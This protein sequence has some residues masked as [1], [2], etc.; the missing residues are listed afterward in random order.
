MSKHDHL[1]FHEVCTF[2]NDFNQTTATHKCGRYSDSNQEP[3]YHNLRCFM[4]NAKRLND[5]HR[6]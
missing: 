4:A 3:L 6:N 1:K 2:S 5:N